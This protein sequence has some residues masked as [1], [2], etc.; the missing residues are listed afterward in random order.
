LHSNE[1]IYSTVTVSCFLPILTNWLALIDCA[2][3]FNPDPAHFYAG[4]PGI[5]EIGFARNKELMTMNQTSGMG[6]KKTRSQKLLDLLACF[7]D[8]LVVAHNNPDPDAI[9]SGWVVAHLV[10]RKLGKPAR[11][12]AGGAIVRAENLRMGELL[13]P[14]LELVDN[15]EPNGKRAAVLVDSKPTSGNHL[16]A[17]AGIKPV[18]VIDHHENETKRFRAAFRDIRPRVA[19]LAS[20]ATEYLI[21]QDV[22]PGSDLATALLNAIRTETQGWE[23]V[24]SRT[25]RRAIS[26][27][28]D[29]YDPAKLHE[30]E[31]APLPRRYFGD[32]LLA[33]ENTFIYRDTAISF[34][35]RANGP[36]IVGEVADTLVRCEG[37]ERVLCTAVYN[38]DL[39]ISARSTRAGGDAV[40][41]LE[42][43]LDDVGRCG[44]H[45]HR[46]GGKIPGVG[47]QSPGGELASRLRVRWLAACGIS[48][49]RGSRLL[50]RKEI[51]NHL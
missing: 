47:A 39:L 19:A 50:A 20:M 33:L 7:D 37:V 28:S 3:V 29:R 4:A 46:A 41:L 25:D 34:L 31:N 14:P 49:Q 5:K 10:E 44:G 45:R 32:L 17:K 48:R 8:V 13:N 22:E 11:L 27:L 51:V 21:E 43:T 16:L 24:Y 40:A 18:A 38:D 42:R 23:A 30:I 36:E 9:A 26:W 35:P 1:R 6:R 15:I 12:V 2:I